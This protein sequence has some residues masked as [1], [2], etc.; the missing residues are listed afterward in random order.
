MATVRKLYRPHLT[1]TALEDRTVPAAVAGVLDFGFE[2]STVATFKYNP[3]GSPWAFTGSAGLTG[4][5]TAF[6]AGNPAA[7]QGGQ[8]AFLQAKGSV[9]QSMTLAAGTY[10]VSF[11]AAQRGNQASPRRSTSSSTARSSAASTT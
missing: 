2:A 7:P 11:S 10:V 3:A 5:G 8:V 4:N 9:T 6:T 1:L